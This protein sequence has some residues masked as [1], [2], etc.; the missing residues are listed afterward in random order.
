MISRIFPSAKEH[1]SGSFADETIKRGS[2]SFKTDGALILEDIVDTAIIAEARRQFT[3]SYSRYL[4]GGEYDDA[5]TVGD[6]RVY[7]T[8]NLSPPF[9]SPQ[10]FAN[11]YLLPILGAALGDDFVIGAYGAVCSLPS[12]AAQLR[13]CDGELLF[14][15][16]GIDWLVPPAAISVVIPLIEMNEI[17]GT[18]ML[19]L[20][21]HRDQKRS[22]ELLNPNGSTNFADVRVEPVVREGSCMLWDFRLVHCGTTNRGVL[23]RPLLCVTYCRP[24]FLDHK[25]FTAEDNPKQKPILASA[26]FLAN[27]PAQQQRLFARAAMG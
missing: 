6:G 19:W 8:I 14:S 26:D 13:H 15:R 12:A 20:G 2:R 27:L 5:R 4:N 11:P 21:S 18:T 1:T 7:I 22:N 3:E 10:L 16:T 24:W 9:D 23:P 25:N 17:H